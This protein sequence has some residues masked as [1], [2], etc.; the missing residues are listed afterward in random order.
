MKVSIIIPVY[1]GSNFIKSSIE[2]ALSQTYKNIE[3]I[4]I[5]DGSN[6]NNETEKIVKSFGK[7][8]KYYKKENGGTSSAINYGITKAT[9]EYISWLSHDDLYYPDKIEKEVR[10]LG[11]RKDQIVF[12]DY[13]YIDEQGNLIEDIII[14]DKLIST[15]PFYVFYKRMICGI[16]LLIPKQFLLEQGMFDKKLLCTQDYDMWYKLL[17]NY[18]FVYLNKKTAKV[19]LHTSQDSNTKSYVVDENEKFWKRII[20][21]TS[22]HII[23]RVFLNK[24]NFY[25]EMYN[26]LKYSNYEKIKLFLKQE[27]Y[28]TYFDNI[29]DELIQNRFEKIKNSHNETTHKSFII[30]KKLKRIIAGK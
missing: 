20:D 2:S 3:V 17:N 27:L 10:I 28:S 7:R 1:N 26:T 30:K 18:D 24:F 12:S 14:K 16:S 19:R 25:L 8:I 23:N 11:N 29:I 22:D 21:N 5:N 4:V 13:E 15:D 9:G 6:D